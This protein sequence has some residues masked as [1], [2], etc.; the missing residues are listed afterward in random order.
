MRVRR[1]DGIPTNGQL[2][3]NPD[4]RLLEV[5]IGSPHVF[6][7]DQCRLCNA[8]V[9]TADMAVQWTLAV[10]GCPPSMFVYSDGTA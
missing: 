4:I 1:N 9:I 5:I 6:G 3:P 7:R 10:C 2:S 8:M